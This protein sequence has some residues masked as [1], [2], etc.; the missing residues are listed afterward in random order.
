MGLIWETR[1]EVQMMLSS[2]PV[3]ISLAQG[4]DVAATGTQAGSR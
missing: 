3:L 2:V 1:T 4:E